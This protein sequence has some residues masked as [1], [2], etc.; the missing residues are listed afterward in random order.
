MKLSFGSNRLRILAIPV[1]LGVLWLLLFHFVSDALIKPR[2]VGSRAELTESTIVR[3]LQYADIY[4][5]KKGKWPN[6][7]NWWNELADVLPPGSEKDGV[8]GLK[9]DAWGSQIRCRIIQSGG[10]FEFHFCSFG[11]NR[12]D[13]REKGDD[14]VG[15]L[16]NESVTLKRFADK[17]Q[18]RQIK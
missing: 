14:I 8:A 11:P 15:I 5:S 13:D 3:L 4:K 9:F 17:A 6:Q 7:D 18:D 10:E 2:D 12:I 16:K 1:V